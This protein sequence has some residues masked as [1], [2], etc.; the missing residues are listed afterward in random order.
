[1]IK[2]KMKTSAFPAA[3]NYQWVILAILSTTHMIMA[4]FFYSWGP[5][6]PLLKEKLLIN[7]SQFGLINSTM[8]FAMVIVSIPSGFLTDKYGVKWL[9][10]L[11]GS[12]MGVAFFLLSLF[13]FYG[14]LFVIST[15]AGA[16]YGMINQISAKGIMYWFEPNKRATVMGIKQTGITIGASL[17]GVYIP[18]FEVIMGW[19][20]AVLLLVVII[21]GILLFSFFFYKEKPEP[22][23]NSLSSIQQDR[24]KQGKVSVRSVLLRPT[25]IFT[26]AVFTLFAI[27]QACLTAFLVIY[28]HEVFHLSMAISGSLFTV[29]MVGGT[30]SRVLFGLISD[31][32]FRGD[33][34]APLALVALIGVLST[35][36]VVFLNDK[37]PLWLLYIISTFLGVALMGW[38]SLAIVLVAEIAGT[39]LIGSVMG[40]LFAIAWGGMV[41]GPPIFGALVDL[42]GYKSGWLMLS[43]LLGISFSGLTIIRKLKISVKKRSP[44]LKGN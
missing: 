11:S 12:L 27:C 16:G 30:I 43:I 21:F 13:P 19:Q 40:V 33:R 15:L 41:I 32:L 37:P 20:K 18:F 34:V 2:S 44:V 26:T 35:V 1:M 23:N 8:Y 14:F 39:E 6:A 38:N 4:M 31:R 25:L 24:L 7:N 42:N 17:I 9:L 28:V 29:A 36:S 10:V 5:L 22:L 3:I